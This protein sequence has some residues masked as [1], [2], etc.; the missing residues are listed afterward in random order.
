MF[1]GVP[2]GGG[3][4]ILS[5]VIDSFDEARTAIV[6]ANCRHAMGEGGRLLLVEPVLP[7]R[8]GAVAA[9]A[10]QAELLMDLDMLVRTGGCERTESEYRGFLAA[11][12]LRLERIVPTGTPVSLIEAAPA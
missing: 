1:V 10:V 8:I 3:R 4:Y 7:D 6:L 5:R 12:G 2:G 9:P 11:A